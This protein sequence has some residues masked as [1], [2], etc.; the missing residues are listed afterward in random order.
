MFVN[1]SVVIRG[2][3]YLAGPKID[4]EKKYNGVLLKLDL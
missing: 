4:L 3:A 2:R 1:P